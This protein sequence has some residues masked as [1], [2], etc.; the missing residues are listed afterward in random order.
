MFV[1]TRSN[2]E[3]IQ[4]LKVM[5]LLKSK[6]LEN[7]LLLIPRGAFVPEDLHEIAYDDRPIRL[8]T[9]GFN[10]SAP[11]MHVLCL[12]ALNI[13]PGNIILDI[14]CGTGHLTALASYLTGSKGKVYGIDL[15]QDI[16]DFARSNVEELQKKTCIDFRNLHFS[17]RN[18]FVPNTDEIKYD[19]IHVGAA[20]PKEK[21]KDLYD[22]LVEGGIIITPCGDELIKATKMENGEMKVEVIANVKYGD[23]V[24]PSDNDIKEALEKL[25]RKRQTKILIPSN[26][27]ITDIGEL[28]N[29][30]TYSDIELVCGGQSVF[31]HKMILAA[32]SEYFNERLKEDTEKLVIEGISNEVF[33]ICLKYIYT[34]AIPEI[35]S[36][37]ALPILEGANLF[38]L[39]RLK[40]IIEAN[41]RPKINKE[42]VIQWLEIT[43]KYGADQL[44]SI[45]I[46]YIVENYDEVTTMEEFKNLDKKLLIEVTQE[47]CKRIVHKM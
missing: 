16:I 5:K 47:A 8:P 13:K 39:Q 10:M 2:E 32:R 21:L 26:S 12:E 1:V 4:K 40:S 19:R 20:C 25:E 33:M 28:I 43:D 42:N 30:K 17:V 3:L 18:C 11:H 36:E 38:K 15:R 29:D 27:L 6:D 34:D 41:L 23:L 31:A 46:D 7:A 45:C 14:G 37:N 22:Q 24:M 9:F 44:Y 35:N